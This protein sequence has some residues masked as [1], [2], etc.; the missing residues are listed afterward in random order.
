[1]MAN[2]YEPQIKRAQEKKQQQQQRRT[3][4]FAHKSSDKVEKSSL[5]NQ[6]LTQ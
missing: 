2:A 1:M 5:K 4:V 6:R 3:E